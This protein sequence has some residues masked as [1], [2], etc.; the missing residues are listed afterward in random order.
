[1]CQ[2]C[3]LFLFWTDCLSFKDKQTQCN[4]LTI[5]F[6]ACCTT[7]SLQVN[8]VYKILHA[9]LRSLRRECVTHRARACR[10]RD[11]SR[12]LKTCKSPTRWTS[13]T[14]TPHPPPQTGRKRQFDIF[15]FK[16]PSIQCAKVTVH[17]T[18]CFWKWLS[19]TNQGAGFEE[20]RVSWII[21]IEPLIHQKRVKSK[22]CRV[23]VNL[24]F[25]AGMYRSQQVFQ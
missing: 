9:A 24:L 1:M 14:P 19:S 22:D 18:A 10:G 4:V 17:K 23:L 16:T 21:R 12:C 11:V 15:K 2:N 3:Q 8:I 5:L 6:K 7:S 25:H 20:I 13:P